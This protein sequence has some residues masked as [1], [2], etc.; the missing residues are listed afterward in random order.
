MDRGDEDASAVKGKMILGFAHHSGR[1][2]PASP[3]L[4]SPFLDGNG[5]TARMFTA[6]LLFQ[7]WVHFKYL[8]DLSIYYNQDRDKYYEALRTADATGD[9]PEW[10]SYF[11][12]GCSYQMVKI[13]ERARAGEN[14]NA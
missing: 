1:H 2:R 3:G 9:Y 8:F 11:L 14:A 6:L 13:K 5:R 4:D 10:R 12:G 7:R